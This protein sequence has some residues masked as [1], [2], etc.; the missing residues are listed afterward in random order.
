MVLPEY[1]AEASLYRTS[2]SYWG[3]GC[4]HVPGAGTTV[5]PQQDPCA[6]AGGGGG[7]GGGGPSPHQCAAGQRCC[8]PA[9]NGLCFLCAPINAQCP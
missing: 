4:R 9:P 7:G 1:A 5:V 2:R 6:I 3:A 8:E